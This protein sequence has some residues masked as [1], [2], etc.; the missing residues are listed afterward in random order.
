MVSRQ[1]IADQKFQEKTERS[2]SL[3]QRIA[4]EGCQPLQTLIGGESVKREMIRENKYGLSE[5]ENWESFSIVNGEPQ[6]EKDKEQK[7]Y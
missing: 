6:R 1:E 2:L 3:K 4:Y 5:Q 7:V